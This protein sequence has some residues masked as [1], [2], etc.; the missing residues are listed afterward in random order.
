MYSGLP[1]KC[2]R[3]HSFPQPTGNLH[4]DSVFPPTVHIALLEGTAD[5]GGT[6]LG[7]RKPIVQRNPDFADNEQTPVH[8][9]EEV[10]E[11]RRA[12]GFGRILY[13]CFCPRFTFLN[14]LFKEQHVCFLQVL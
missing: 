4:T 7:T 3:L 6:P 11:Y 10:R 8:L 12:Y 1:E 9:R 13:A 14:S 2:Q 5:L